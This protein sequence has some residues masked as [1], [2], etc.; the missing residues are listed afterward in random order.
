MSSY[1]L[2]FLKER[3]KGLG[4]SP[5]RTLVKL[6]SD[7]SCK[8]RFI[9]VCM[10]VS[11]SSIYCT[12]SQVGSGQDKF[13]KICEIGEVKMS[14]TMGTISRHLARIEIYCNLTTRVH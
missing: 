14:E 6:Y 7:I 9:S 10:T 3:S 13:T 11:F 5:V 4:G 1:T 2:F 12:C 8:I